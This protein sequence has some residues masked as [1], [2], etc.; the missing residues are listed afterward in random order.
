ME[1]QLVHVRQIV[2][3]RLSAVDALGLACK[4]R[5]KFNAPVKLSIHLDGKLAITG[6]STAY[7]NPVL[8]AGVVHARALLEFLGLIAHPQHHGRLQVRRKARR[9]DIGIEQFSTSAGA[10][11]LVTPEDAVRDYTGDPADAEKALAYV[12]HLANKGIAHHTTGLVIDD[13]DEALIELAARGLPVLFRRHFYEPLGCELPE[14]HV[15]TYP[16]LE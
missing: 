11:P 5:K 2:A 4:L 1:D 8:E 15:K 9:D 7:T 14:S 6:L 13:A 10:L 3:Y 16:A 12:I